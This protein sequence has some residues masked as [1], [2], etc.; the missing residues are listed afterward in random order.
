MWVRPPVLVKVDRCGEFLTHFGTDLDVCSI[1]I[2]MVPTESQWP[3][4][5]RE[6]VGA[7]LAEIL[8][9]RDGMRSTRGWRYATWGVT[10][11]YPARHILVGMVDRI[12]G[13][14][15]VV[16]EHGQPYWHAV[17]QQAASS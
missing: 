9:T 6:R 17:W 15:V 5:L 3:E 14:V 7:I 1:E 4:G 12:F 10:P 13:S 16:S 8:E 2:Q 11:G